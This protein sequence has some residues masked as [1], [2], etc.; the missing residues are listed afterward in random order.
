M[1]DLPPSY[2]DLTRRFS[3]MSR[4]DSALAILQWDQEVMMPAA[5]GDGRADTVAVLSG[6]RHEMLTDPALSE[7][8]DAAEGETAALDDWQRANLREMRRAWRH[9][10]AVPADLVEANARATSRCE[11][12]WRSARKDSDFDGFRPHLQEVLTLQRRIGETKAAQLGVSLYDAL[13]DGFEPEGRSARIDAVFDDLAGFL[14]GF[15]AEVLEAQARRPRAEPP[16]GP[17]PI[18]TQRHLGLELMRTVGFDD[19]R[20]RLDISTHPFCG[21]TD[22]D[23]RIT[24]RYDETDFTSALMGVLHETGHAIYEQGRPRDWLD[25]PVG[26]ARGMVLHESQSLL[27]EMQVCRGR[28]FLGHAAP[29]MRAAFDGAGPAWETDSLYRLY[30]KVEPG[31]IRVDADEVT[32]PAHVIL[33]Y[34]LEKALLAGD[35]A[36]ADL[37]G[38]WAEQSRALLGLTPPDDRRGC[39]QDIHWPGGAWGYFPTYTLG[40]MAAAQLFQAACQAVPEIPAAIRAGDF[41]PLR[42]WLRRE[43]HERGSL[44]GTDDLLTA[45]TGAPLSADAF[46]THLTNRYLHDR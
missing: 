21:G 4:L 34:R 1:S 30:T 18:D 23:V 17:F 28:D 8:L 22:D 35:L 14:P 24:T 5:A 33:R 2:A 37:P 44:L 27:V 9:A 20:G 15:L 42:G 38:A 43:V 36:L 31:H 25:Q 11:L 7:A 41:A 46:K 40:A 29:R 3:R 13:L 10:V 39:L 32:Y 16:T 26:Q 19:D 12:A 45:A 6:L